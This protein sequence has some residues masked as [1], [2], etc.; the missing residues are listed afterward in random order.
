ML[1][2]PASGD[3]SRAA[4]SATSARNR[5]VVA[6][7]R[8]RRRTRRAA[9]DRVRE[10][11]AVVDAEEALQPGRPAPP[12][13]HPGKPVLRLRVR[14]MRR[15]AEE[16]FARAAHVARAEARV[17]AG[18][19]QPIEPKSCVV[20]YD[21]ATGSFDVFAPTQG[22]SMMRPNLESS[23]GTPLDR[24][25]LH[26]GDVGRRLRH[27]LSGLPGILRADARRKI[28]RKPV[29]MGR[30]AA[31]D[32]GERSSRPRIQLNGELALA[33]TAGSSR[34]RVRWVCNMGAYL[35]QPG[36]L[37]N[38]LKSFVAC[39][40]RVSHPRAPW[41]PQLALTNTTPTT[42]YRGRRR[43]GVSYLVE[44]LVDEAARHSGIDPH[45]ASSAQPDSE[46]RHSPTRPDL[47]LRQ[48]RPAR[49]ARGGALT[50]R[51]GLVRKAARAVPSN[52][53]HRQPRRFSKTSPI[54]A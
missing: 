42:A 14:A 47:D 33:A 3:V 7:S 13:R 2:G 10:L 45:R 48:R 19:G 21:T 26:H 43:P 49:R 27:P 34:W 36:P 54:R 8:R 30:H 25:R 28:A 35:S 12:R 18:R 5:V 46:R 39:D 24:I 40:Q 4:A 37:I 1:K 16:A 20:A 44:R 38:S 6:T 22:M 53:P 52:L 9:R 11:P 23:T 29:E 50:L 31:R 15:P 17:D 32:P 51:M 41:P